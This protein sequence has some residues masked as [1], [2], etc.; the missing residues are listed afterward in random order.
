MRVPLLPKWLRW[1]AVVVAAALVAAF[2]VIR[3]P[4]GVAATGPFGLVP[5]SQYGHFVAYAGLA[6]LLAY[7]LAD[8][9]WSDRRVLA[10]V[11]LVAVGYGFGL[12]AIQRLLP[13][14]RFEVGDLVVNA[15]GTAL[16]VVLWRLLLARVRFYRVS[17]G[18]SSTEIRQ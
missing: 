14:R 16:A 5:M 1:A 7:A 6:G 15:A 9:H 13:Y 2:S 8:S 18:L 10:V 12:E 3:L 11:F 4:P 17:A